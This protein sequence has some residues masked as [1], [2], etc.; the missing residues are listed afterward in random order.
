MLGLVARQAGQE[1]SQCEE[2]CSKPRPPGCP[3]S[4]P[5]PCHPGECP[6]CAQMIRMKCH[7]KLTSLYIECIKITSAD[8][9]EKDVLSSCKNQ[10]PKEGASRE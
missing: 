1:C 6:T 3:H 5:L 9:K 10:C 7:C 8:L 4:C 2:E